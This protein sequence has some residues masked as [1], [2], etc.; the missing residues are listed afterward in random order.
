[1]TSLG[2]NLIGDSTGGSGYVD[3]TN[4][5]LVGTTG[6]P[7][8]AKLNPLSDNGGPTQ[9]HA[10]LPGS[11]AIDLGNNT[12]ALATDQ[13]GQ[14]RVVGERCDIGAYELQ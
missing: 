11:P 5:D 14:P 4:G 13:R 12:D 3:G 10:L 6:N 2:S 9:T 8:D 7:L 1:M